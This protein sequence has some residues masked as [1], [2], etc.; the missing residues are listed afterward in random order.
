MNYIAY[1]V[2]IGERGTCFK[3]R[4]KGTEYEIVL[5]VPGIHN[6]SNA[7]AAIAVG[8]E[9]GLEPGSIVEGISHFKPEKLRLNFIECGGI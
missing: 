7:M 2:R 5:N 4:L 8:A 9:L 3:T 6:V 1:D